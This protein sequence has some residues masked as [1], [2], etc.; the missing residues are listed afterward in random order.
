MCL[1]VE[2]ICESLIAQWGSSKITQKALEQARTGRTHANSY[3]N[4]LCN[5]RPA[6]ESTDSTMRKQILADKRLR[7]RPPLRLLPPPNCLFVKKPPTELPIESGCILCQR[8][9]TPLPEQ[10]V[11][12]WDITALVTAACATFHMIPTVHPLFHK[13]NPSRRRKEIKIDSLLN[14]NLQR[15]VP[16]LFLNLILTLGKTLLPISTTKPPLLLLLIN[17]HASHVKSCQQ[18]G[19]T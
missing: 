5:E 15:E 7:Q 3:F 1:H 14:L 18:S 10:P 2:K 13:L 8:R 4:K 16:G 17:L 6:G 12:R 11:R 9:C 19:P